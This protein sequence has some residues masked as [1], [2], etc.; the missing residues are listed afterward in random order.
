MLEAQLA[1]SWPVG[2]CQCSHPCFLHHGAQAVHQDALTLPS[3]KREI[4]FQE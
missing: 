2:C 4:G 1:S 3:S